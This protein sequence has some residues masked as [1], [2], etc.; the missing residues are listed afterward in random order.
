MSTSNS[1]QDD[2]DCPRDRN[3][4]AKA[5]LTSMLNVG[6]FKDNNDSRYEIQKELMEVERN[7]K[8]HRRDQSGLNRE[9]FNIITEHIKPS[10]TSNS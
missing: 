8:A 5:V 10:T 1:R 6:K 3:L 2:E 7:I 9:R 4:Q